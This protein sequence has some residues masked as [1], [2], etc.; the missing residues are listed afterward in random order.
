MECVAPTPRVNVLVILWAFLVPRLMWLAMKNDSRRGANDTEKE[1]EQEREGRRHCSVAW[2]CTIIRIPRL[3]KILALSFSV[4]QERGKIFQ[5]CTCLSDKHIA[6]TGEE[7]FSHLLI[8][9]SQKTRKTRHCCC[10][11]NV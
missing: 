5:S 7:K 11:G 3:I 4:L 6:N 8:M 1:R 9:F 10:P 2:G